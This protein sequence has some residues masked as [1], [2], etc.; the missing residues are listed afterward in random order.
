MPT[1][2]WDYSYESTKKHHPPAKILATPME[3]GD[4]FYT[5][6]APMMFWIMSNCQNT[7]YCS[8]HYSVQICQLYIV[9]LLRIG[10]WIVT[11][12]LYRATMLYTMKWY[13][14]CIF[15]C[16][17]V[18]FYTAIER[19]SSKFDSWNWWHC[20]SY[21]RKKLCTFISLLIWESKHTC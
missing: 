12:R 6:S 21:E 15:Y 19:R 4:H 18:L 13:R 10:Y 17:A 20:G 9:F 1:W 2:K 11:I 16:Y 14:Y 8:L 7:N 3:E 5:F